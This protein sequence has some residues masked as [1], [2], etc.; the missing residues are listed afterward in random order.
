M[1]AERIIRNHIFL[2]RFLIYSL[3]ETSSLEVFTPQS[4]Y[5]IISISVAYIPYFTIPI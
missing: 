4:N 5:G 1:R 3:E 2:P